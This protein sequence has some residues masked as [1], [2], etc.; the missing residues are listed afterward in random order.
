M[1][2]LFRAALV[3]LIT[4]VG[5]VFFTGPAQAGV[6]ELIKTTATAAKDGGIL[7]G[8]AALVLLYIFKAIPNAKIYSSVKTVFVKLG[9]AMTLGLSKWKWSAPLWSKTIEPW[10]IDFIDNIV[11][12]AVNGFILGLRSD[13]PPDEG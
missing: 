2:T 10:V 6:M 8:L 4:L 12:A 1:K 5:S 7:Y 9:T 13:N 11:G 3:L